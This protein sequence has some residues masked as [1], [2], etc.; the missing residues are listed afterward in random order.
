MTTIILIIILVLIIVALALWLPQVVENT[1]IERMN[2][3]LEEDTQSKHSAEIKKMKLDDVEEV[4]E[5]SD[6]D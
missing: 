6:S 2:K 5:E 1:V 3:H 4:V